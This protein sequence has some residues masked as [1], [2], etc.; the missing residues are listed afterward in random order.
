MPKVLEGKGR[1]ERLWGTF[2]DR[3]I[4]EL[5]LEGISSLEGA[6]EYLHSVFLSKYRQ[7]FT[8]KPKVEESAYRII[9]KGMDLDQILCI[10]EKRRVQGDNTISYNGKLYQIL[11]TKTRFGFAKAKVEVQK[12]LDGTI[13]IFYQGEELPFKPIIPQEDE[14]YAPSQTEALAVGV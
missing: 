8:R 2:Q 6:N 4:T 13:H 12:H 7:K 10:K 3:L 9:P 5:R 1:S 11:P 14:R